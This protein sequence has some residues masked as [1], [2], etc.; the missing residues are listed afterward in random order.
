ME[1][2]RKYK[3]SELATSNSSQYS[4]NEK[5]SIVRYLD[6]GSITNNIIEEM[7][8]IRMGVDEFPSRARRKVKRGDIIYSTV[9]PNQKHFGYIENPAENMLVSTGFTVLSVNEDVA[10]S[11]YLYYW[12]SQQSIIDYLHAVGEQAVSAYPTIKAKDIEDLEIIL[13]P[14]FEQRHISS[15]LTCID[16]K[17]ELNRRINDNLEQQA[18]AL[19]KS[20]FVNFE[21]FRGGKFVDSELGMIPEDWKVGTLLDI[22]NIKMGQS[23]SGSSFNENGDGIIFYQGRT[24]FG[25]RFPSIRLYTTE[26][27]RYAVPNSVLLSVRAPVGDINITTKSCC[28][29]RGIAS[30]YSRDYYSSFLFYTL[31]TLKPMFDRFNGE[32]TVFGSINKKA[33]EE[34]KILLPTECI[35][36]KFET[37]VNPL[38][39]HIQELSEEVLVLSNYRDNLLPR[40]M[41]GELKINEMN[42]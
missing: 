26:P 19:Y 39:S 32:G 12:L 20:W 27:T 14:L 7:Q 35:L 23:P 15:I 37:I 33:L 30:L 10:D 17:I 24:E 29:G 6:T 41:S 3:I 16:S 25:K 18:Q 1:E 40:L 2:N 28:I 8:T 42:S 11:K 5:W 31:K 38:D 21:P 13:P 4:K 9:R 36:L 34:M 22:A